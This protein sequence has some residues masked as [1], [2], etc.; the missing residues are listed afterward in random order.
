VLVTY[1]HVEVEAPET[2]VHVAT[3]AWQTEAGDPEGLQA[4]FGAT[5][6]VVPAELPPVATAEQVDEDGP[7]DTQVAEAAQTVPLGRLHALDTEAVAVV[8][9]EHEE[10]EM[11]R[12]LQ[13]AL[14]PQTVPLAVWQALLTEA[15]VVAPAAVGEQTEDPPDA[16]QVAVE[17]QTVPEAV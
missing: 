3:P 14:G 16:T 10:D 12:D 2:P 13:V 4:F 15:V 5:V 17:P 8:V 11:P 1:A 9:N 6:T 7:R